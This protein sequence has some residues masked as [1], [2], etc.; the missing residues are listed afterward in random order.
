MAVVS[1]KYEANSGDIHPIRVGDAVIAV[2]GNTVPSGAQTSSISAKISKGAREFG[3]KPRGVLLKRLVG[4]S[5]DQAA[6]YAFLP[7]LS[8][9]VFSGA[10]FDPGTSHT[11]NGNSWEVSKKIDEDSD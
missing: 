4:T 3:L 5:P 8:D 11:Y 7:I 9:S 6:K 10:T 1:S 2:S